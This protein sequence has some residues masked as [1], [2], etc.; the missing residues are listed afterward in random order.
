M[1]QAHKA[2]LEGDQARAAIQLTSLLGEVEHAEDKVIEV[3][4]DW[5]SRQTISAKRLAATFSIA[6]AIVH[7]LRLEY[8]NVNLL[9]IQ[10]I[11]STQ[12][13][14]LSYILGAL[15]AGFFVAMCWS[16]WNDWQVRRVRLASVNAEMSLAENLVDELHKLIPE[17]KFPRLFIHDP[18][19]SRD[20]QFLPKAGRQYALVRYYRSQ[21]KPVHSRRIWLELL[22]FLFVGFAFVLACK[23]LLEYW[24]VI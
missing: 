15:M 14:T 6:L 9:W 17:H 21:I 2:G 4:N 24:G 10:N 8:S 5:Q 20:I 11:N 12:A 19:Q 13:L 3:F 22:E 16:V 18:D 23:G 1:I 7:M